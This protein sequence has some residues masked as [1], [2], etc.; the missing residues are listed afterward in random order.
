[1]LGL[2]A[3]LAL[4]V[5]GGAGYGG[6]RLAGSTGEVTRA[7]APTTPVDPTASTDPTVEPSAD[8]TAEPTPRAAAPIDAVAVAAKT[9]PSTVM[10]RVG[11][12][13]G[14]GFVF[15]DRGR[16]LTNNHVVAGAADG[17][18]IRVVFSDGKRQK[19]TLVGRSPS[20]DVAVIKVETVLAAAPGHPGQ[21]GAHPGR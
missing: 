10:I 4:V 17:S 5:G 18:T 2:A 14:S 19:A 15:D 13:T 20:Y 9:V 1:M 6:A 16:I 12:A 7:A 3:A 21:R 8:P 11:R